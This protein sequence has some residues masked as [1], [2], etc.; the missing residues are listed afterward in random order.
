MTSTLLSYRNLRGLRVQA[1]HAQPVFAGSLASFTV[2]IDNP[3]RR[4]RFAILA[5]LGGSDSSDCADLP[6]GHSARLQLEIPALQRG[7]L[8]LPAVRLETRYPMGMFRAWSW[9]FPNAACLVYPLPAAQPPPLPL[10][11][12]GDTGL[13]LLGEG[14]QVHGLRPY[15]AGDSLRRVAWRTSARHDELYSREMEIPQE[16][17]CRLR[18]NLLAGTETETRLSILAAWV[19]EADRRQLVWSL[20]LPATTI[21]PGSGADH[22]GRCLRALAL[23]GT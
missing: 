23:H 16:Q 10:S 8:M 3:E 1:I 5:G 9:L 20:E 17:L 4:T 21:D 18:W 19:L 15:R 2:H 11:G 7:W 6:P 13:A 12:Q 22:L 14:D